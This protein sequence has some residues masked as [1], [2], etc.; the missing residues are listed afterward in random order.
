MDRNDLHERIS[1]QQEMMKEMEWQ[2]KK[3]CMDF[4]SKI[5]ELELERSI[6]RLK[7]KA[8]SLMFI[9]AVAFVSS[10]FGALMGVYYG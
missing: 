3:V 8:E 10:A 1:R 9:F 5:V 4:R 6:G 2:H 7:T